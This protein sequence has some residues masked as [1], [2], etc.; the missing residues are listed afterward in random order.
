MSWILDKERE[1]GYLTHPSGELFRRS[2][3]VYVYHTSRP[4]CTRGA[5]RTSSGTSQFSLHHVSLDTVIQVG[6]A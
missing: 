1:P 3:P 6:E 5:Q 4:Q 2:F